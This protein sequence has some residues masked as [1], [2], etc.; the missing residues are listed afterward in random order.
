MAEREGLLKTIL[1]F[2]PAGARG[3]T[4]FVPD[5]FVKPSYDVPRLESSNPGAASEIQ[6]PAKAG[7][8]I[9]GGEGGIRTLEGLF[10]PLLP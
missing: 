2:H 3:A 10:K 5:K 4:K 1:G 7:L 8:G 9:S 6:N